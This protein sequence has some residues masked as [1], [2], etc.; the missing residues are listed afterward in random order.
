MQIDFICFTK[1]QTKLALN[2]LEIIFNCDL[3]DQYCKCNL[4]Y[5]YFSMVTLR[6][7]IYLYR[8]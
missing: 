6:P 1:K 4:N 5:D 3:F 7:K 8:A 2:D